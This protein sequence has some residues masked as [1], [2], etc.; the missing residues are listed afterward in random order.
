MNDQAA[1][2]L[3]EYGIF[4]WAE[5]LFSLQEEFHCGQSIDR[6]AIIEF[7]DLFASSLNPESPLL[8]DVIDISLNCPDSG[9]DLLKIVSRICAN[10]D[11]CDIELARK[12]WRVAKLISVLK[13]LEPNS[14]YSLVELSEFWECWGWPADMPSSARMEGIDSENYAAPEH[15]ASVISDH[16]EWLRAQLLEVGRR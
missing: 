15:F 3:R 14:I 16:E 9:A 5:I 2:I 7:A 12:R 1:N 10:T 11:N 8:S 6:K 4:G 13:D